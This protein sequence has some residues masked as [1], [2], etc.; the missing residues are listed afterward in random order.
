MNYV[1]SLQNKT[2]DRI[3]YNHYGSSFGYLELVLQHNNFLYEQEI[4]LPQGL[5]IY[6]PEVA[7]QP[8]E[9]TK[10]W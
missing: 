3:V 4:I 8:Q 9:R 2:L 5:I 1:V 7:K 10:L 6:L